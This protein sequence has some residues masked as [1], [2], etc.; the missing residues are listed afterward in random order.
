METTNPAAALPGLDCG[1]C[2]FRTCNDLAARLEVSPGLIKRCIYLSDNRVGAQPQTPPPAAAAGPTVTPARPSAA[3]ATCGGACNRAETL[4]PGTWLDSLGR[5]FDFYLE[6]FP[7]DPGPREIIIPHNPMITREME[8]KVG[9]TL[10][11]RPLG[12]S[13]GCPR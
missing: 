4:P 1:V 6:H 10:I 12:M 3:A 8:I 7:E 9:D 11:G 13:C 5:E 2:G